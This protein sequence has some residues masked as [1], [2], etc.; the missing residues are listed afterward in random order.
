VLVDLPSE[1]L[2]VGAGGEGDDL[3]SIGVS[4]GDVEC[5]CSDGSG[6]AENG[7]ALA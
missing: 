1:E 4:G 3:D 5:L 7:E 6:G 2:R